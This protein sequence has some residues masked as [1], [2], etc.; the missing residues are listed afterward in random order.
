MKRIIIFGT[1]VSAEKIYCNIKKD[2]VEVVA[3]LDNDQKK[4]GKLFHGVKIVSP[5][6]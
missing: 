5:E 4:Q 3:Y 6:E 2:D 1:S